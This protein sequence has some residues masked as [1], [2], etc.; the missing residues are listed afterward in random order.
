MYLDE[1]IY[2]DLAR[3]AEQENKSRA[4][5]ARDILK[6]GLAKRKSIDQSG[7]AVLLAIADLRLAGG[8]DPYLSGNVD[9]YLYGAPKNKL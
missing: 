1:D 5:I 3:V 8:A 6:E 4:E 2:T 7:K 9:H